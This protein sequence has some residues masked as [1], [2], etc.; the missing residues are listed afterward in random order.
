M[1]MS[2]N[3]SGKRTALVFEALRIDVVQACAAARYV[4]NI[5][6]EEC[7]SGQMIE[8]RSGARLLA[9]RCRDPAE[10]ATLEFDRLVLGHRGVARRT[11]RVATATLDMAFVS[12]VLTLSLA[13]RR[14]AFPIAAWSSVE[15][16]DQAEKTDRRAGHSGFAWAAGIWAD[17]PQGPAGLMLLETH[18]AAP[19]PYVLETRDLTWWLD[20]H[21]IDRQELANRFHRC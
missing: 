3:L 15:R 16:S 14:C 8:V 10:N 11:E 9:L 13:L 20:P 12:P 21:L 6:P 4:A 18:E 17:G 2:S 1:N 7:E 19:L 5:T